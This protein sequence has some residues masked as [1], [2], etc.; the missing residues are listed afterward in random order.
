M[1]YQ[2]RI[3]RPVTDLL[4]TTTLYCR[5]LGLRVI[6]SFEDHQGFDGVMLGFED[7]PYHFEFTYCHNHPV[8]PTPTHED[9]CVLYIP[10]FATW[11]ETCATMEDAGFKHIASFNPYWDVHGRTYEDHDGYRTVLQNN[12]WVKATS[13]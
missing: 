5:G 6:G 7:S 11:Q 1:T 2:L 10:S 13:A 9:L 3:A 12:V 4:K 8:R